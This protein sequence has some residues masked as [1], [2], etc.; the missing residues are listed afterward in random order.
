MH[1]TDLHPPGYGERY[2]EYFRS[3]IAT[4]KVAP[5]QMYAQRKDGERIPIKISASMAHLGGK[6]YVTGV[7]HDVTSEV[8]AAEEMRTRNQELE[9][10]VK[11][12]TG[13]EIK[14]MELKRENE[15]LK[16]RAAGKKG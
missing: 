9:R 15:D 12:T 11:I 14:M 8:A 7:F 1:Q 13:R 16:R 4:G 3:Y 5:E 6:T 2:A 10:F